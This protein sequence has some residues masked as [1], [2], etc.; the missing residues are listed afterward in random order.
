MNV[1]NTIKVFYH[2]LSVVANVQK[3]AGERYFFMEK[4]RAVFEAL[5]KEGL[6]LEHRTYEPFTWKDFE[7]CHDPS[8]VEAVRTGTPVELAESCAIPWSKELVAAIPYA[9]ASIHAATNYAV[10]A[11][12]PTMSMSTGFH[13]AKYLM[14]GS[15]CPLNDLN[16]AAEKIHRESGLR[17]LILDCDYHLGNGTDDIISACNQGEYLHNLSMGYFFSRLYVMHNEYLLLLKEKLTKELRSG[18]PQY[19]IYKAAADVFEKDPMAKHGPLSLK[20]IAKR[21]EMVFSMIKEAGI[22]VA[23]CLG[24]GYHSMEVNILIH[25][26]TFKSCSNLYFNTEH[27]YNFSQTA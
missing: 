7:L 26:N 11:G 27:A 9:T 23:I 10:S 24:G 21:D 16:I 20:E 8:Y 1:P 17:G 2:P 19:V 14:G 25:L 4:P 12:E 22:P 13:H 6:N 5:Q 3:V 18:F 15:L